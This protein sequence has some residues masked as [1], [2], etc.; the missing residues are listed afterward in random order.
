M[1]FLVIY[2]LHIQY[3]ILKILK[4]LSMICNKRVPY[5]GLLLKS[6]KI[7][8]LNQ[9]QKPI[10]DS[11]SQP[12]YSSFPS[13]FPPARASSLHHHI[14]AIPAPGPQTKTTAPNTAKIHT[15]PTCTRPSLFKSPKC[16]NIQYA[17]LMVMKISS[18]FRNSS[19]PSTIPLTFLSQVKILMSEKKRS[20]N[21]MGVTRK[22]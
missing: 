10:K 4:I 22:M 3:L 19:A 8:P 18:H 16:N 5:I 12:H 20:E 17:T 13:S 14:T 2:R 21:G 6:I 7:I 1:N 11:L 9:I 15:H